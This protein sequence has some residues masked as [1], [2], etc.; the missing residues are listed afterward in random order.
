MYKVLEDFDVY[1]NFQTLKYNAHVFLLSS[2]LLFEDQSLLYYTLDQIK[3]GPKVNSR[4]MFSFDM[5]DRF[6]DGDAV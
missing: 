2:N 6:R 3:A 1:R 4:M 5:H